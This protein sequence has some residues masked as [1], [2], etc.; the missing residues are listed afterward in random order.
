MLTPQEVSEHAFARASFGGYNM[1]MVDEFLDLL[2]ADY[3]AL[4][5]EN[6]VLKS[7]MKVLADKV[8]EYRSTEEAMRKALMTAQRM[9]DSL[10]QEAEK[11]KEDILKEAEQEAFGRIAHIRQDAADEEYRLTAARNATAAYVARVRQ[12]HDQ[13]LEFLDKLSQLAPPPPAD[14]PTVE[15]TAQEIEGNVQRLLEQAAQSEQ[16]PEPEQASE[17]EQG[18]EDPE[19][20]DTAEFRVVTRESSLDE[21]EE[22]ETEEM[23]RQAKSRMDGS[24]LRGFGPG[25]NIVM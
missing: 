21:E 8:E 9:A 19:L 16:E 20:A 22:R 4:Y 11:Q 24:R 2:T 23:I 5:N 3:S 13:E 6:A 17:P 12:I 15:Q 18:A 1:A 25:E 14:K 7:K 10:V